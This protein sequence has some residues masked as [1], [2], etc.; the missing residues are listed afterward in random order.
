MFRFFVFVLV[1]DL[2]VTYAWDLVVLGCVCVCLLLVCFVCFVDCF[3]V[4]G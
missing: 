3:M 2:F 1:N 4:V